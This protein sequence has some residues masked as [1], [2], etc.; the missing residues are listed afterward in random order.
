MVNLTP[1]LN[2]RCETRE[3]MT[4]YAGI[5]GGSATFSSYADFGVPGDPGEETKIMHSQLEGST[6]ALM[7]ADL[8]NAIESSPGADVNLSLHG[9]PEEAA[10]LTRI[11]EALTDGGTIVMPLEKAPWGDTFG[12]VVDRYGMQWMV[13]IGG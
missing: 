1:Y 6:V 8:P 7:A 10:D 12:H 2:F 5:F 9:G 3:A 11:F 13:N 4:F